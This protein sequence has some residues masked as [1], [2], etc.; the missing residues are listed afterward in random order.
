MHEQ[1]ITIKQIGFQVSD[2]E[3]TMSPVQDSASQPG[4][5][6]ESTSSYKKF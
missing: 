5:V 6:V 4:T 2:I 1:T 3:M